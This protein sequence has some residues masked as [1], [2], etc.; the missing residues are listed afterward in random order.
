M[1]LRDFLKAGVVLALVAPFPWVLLACDNEAPKEVWCPGSYYY[2]DNYDNG[3]GAHTG[4]YIIKGFFGSKYNKNTY[5][6]DNGLADCSR[7]YF[8]YYSM[9]YKNCQPDHGLPY[10]GW[11]KSTVYTMEI[12]KKP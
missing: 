7:K 1:S 4:A 9:L 11:A 8:C 10:G 12:C 3:C 2:C 5:C 6:Y